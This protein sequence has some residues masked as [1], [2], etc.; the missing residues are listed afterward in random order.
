MCL[1]TLPHRAVAS[2]LL[3]V[4][5]W[6]LR[7]DQLALLLGEVHL[8]T[9]PAASVPQSGGSWS[10]KVSLLKKMLL[11][12]YHQQWVRWLLLATAEVELL[13][14]LN[15]WQFLVPT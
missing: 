7:S 11:L 4:Q 14:S 12:L 15:W 3:P 10:Q 2:P 1:Q 9:V 6:L 13:G 5:V 8:V